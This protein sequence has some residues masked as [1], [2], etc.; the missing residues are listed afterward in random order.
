MV[1]DTI[2]L[3]DAASGQKLS[4]LEG[5]TG[6]VFSA[7]FSPEGRYIVINSGDGTYPVMGNLPMMR[8][9]WAGRLQ[10]QVRRNDGKR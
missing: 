10:E 8:A 2:T 6:Y 4:S 5:Y 9:D 7:A 1:F 3:W